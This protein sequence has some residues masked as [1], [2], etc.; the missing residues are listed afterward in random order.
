MTQR[1]KAQEYLLKIQTGLVNMRK[2]LKARFLND[3]SI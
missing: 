1:E 2:I 3:N